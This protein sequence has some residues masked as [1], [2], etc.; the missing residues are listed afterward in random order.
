[1]TWVTTPHPHL[2]VAGMAKAQQTP[3]L[4]KSPQL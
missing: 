1:M 4:P 3:N 2:F